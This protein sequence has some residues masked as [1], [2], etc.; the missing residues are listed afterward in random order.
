[1]E[2]EMDE[3][4]QV[5]TDIETLKADIDTEYEKLLQTKRDILKWL[6]ADRKAKQAQYVP[7]LSAIVTALLVLVAVTLAR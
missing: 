3:I 5:K 7:I 2:A 4:T 1:M 6:E